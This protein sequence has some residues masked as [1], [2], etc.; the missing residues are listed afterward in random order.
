MHAVVQL[1]SLSHGSRILSLVPFLPLLPTRLLCIFF[2]SSVN[3]RVSLLLGFW[4]QLTGGVIIIDKSGWEL[5]NVDATA[6]SH[7]EQASK[8][9]WGLRTRYI[10]LVNL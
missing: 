4:A 3:K 1:A 2:L 9:S 7:I 6:L 8:I 10:P 5:V